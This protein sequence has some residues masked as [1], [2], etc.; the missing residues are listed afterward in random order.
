M[1]DTKQLV[2]IPDFLRPP[3][4]FDPTHPE[5]GVDPEGRECFSLDACIVP[6]LETLWAYGVQTTGCCCGHGSGR[7]VVGFRTERA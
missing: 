4:D 1:C 2:P 6:V 3:V 5:F 7:G